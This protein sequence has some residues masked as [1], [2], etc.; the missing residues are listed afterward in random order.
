MAIPLRIIKIGTEIDGSFSHM[1]I[2]GMVLKSFSIFLFALHSYT[3]GFDLSN[4]L[5]GN[6]HQSSSHHAVHAS[7]Q[8]DLSSE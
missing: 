2:S 6:K 1:T 5:T 7:K 4:Q 8:R 3:I